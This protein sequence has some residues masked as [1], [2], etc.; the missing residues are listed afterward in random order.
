MLCPRQGFTRPLGFM[1]M[2]LFERIAD[3]CAQHETAVW[4]HFLGEPLPMNDIEAQV[5]DEIRLFLTLTPRGRDEMLAEA[6][7]NLLDHAKRWVGYERQPVSLAAVFVEIL[8][9]QHAGRELGLFPLS[10]A[11]KALIRSVNM[12]KLLKRYPGGDFDQFRALQ[13]DLGAERETLEA[14]VLG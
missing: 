7:N 12:A 6:I 8:F 11:T 1:P 2:A 5:E 14:A 10:D 13:R 3:E 4:L 9:V